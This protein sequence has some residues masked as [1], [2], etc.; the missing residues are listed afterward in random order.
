ITRH[1]G[2][3][4]YRAVVARRVAAEQRRRPKARRLDAC[5]ELRTEVVF[6]LRAGQSP[7]QVAGRLR[8]EHPE[9]KAQW[10]SHAALR[11]VLGRTRTSS[12]HPTAGASA[13]AESHHQLPIH[14]SVLP[15]HV[16][17]KYSTRCVCPP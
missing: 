10:V 8:Y 7:D 2:R 11:A 17:R 3:A 14:V 6:R 5:P 1:G 13:A 12:R 9:Q 16:L 4:G 15:A